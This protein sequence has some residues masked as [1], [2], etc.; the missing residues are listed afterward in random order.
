MKKDITMIRS[1]GYKP[2]ACSMY[3]DKTLHEMLNRCIPQTNEDKPVAVFD[4]DG[5]LFDTRYRQIMIFREFA[6][7]SG[8]HELNFIE[9]HMIV[10]WNLRTP[11]QKLGLSE[12]KIDT[13]YKEMSDYWWKCFFDSDY[14]RMDYAMPGACEFVTKCYEQ[15]AYVVYLTGRDHNMR[16]GTEDCLR[17]FGFPYDTDRS[18]LITK[19]EFSIPDTKYKQDALRQ[20]RGY[21][22]PVLFIDN[23]PSNV[24]MFAETC[25]EAMV[26]FI[27]TDHSPKNIEVNHG[28]PWIRSFSRTEFFGDDDWKKFEERPLI[29]PS[30]YGK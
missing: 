12:V 9:P 3:Q 30:S 2:F 19:P 27:E 4:L 22:E 20:I 21:G 7:K 16:P 13:F 18:T 23:E 5:C 6:S 28:I 25:P 1:R 11:L 8:V 15:N 24:N 17:G 10:D 14:V 26:V 29:Y